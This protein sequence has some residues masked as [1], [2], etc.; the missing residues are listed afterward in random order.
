LDPHTNIL[1]STTA[2]Y[3]AV[4]GGCDSLTV[5]PF[6][7]VLREPDD[8][9]RRIAVNTQHILREECLG[10]AVADPAG[11]SWFVE[12]LTKEIAVNAWTEFQKTEAP[13]ASSTANQQRGEMS[14]RRRI[15]VG[16]NQYANPTEKPL[17]S[18]KDTSE[19]RLAGEFEALRSASWSYA[20]RTGSLPK[21]F[22]LTMG[23]LKQH[24][25]RADFSR[26]FLEPGGFEVIYPAGF[27][28]VAE[29]VTAA[30]SSR[31]LAAVLCST[32]ETYPELVPSVLGELRGSLPLILAGHPTEHIEAFKAAGVA[33]FIHLKADCGKFLAAW[34]QKLGVIS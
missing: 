13:D 7:Q 33:D 22:L 24:K 8:F 21:I 32:D 27:A 14:K 2:G 3:A 23:P 10:E 30:K 6:D 28:T 9:S 11:G 31:A 5:T 26:G 18:T 17:T 12:N 25:A 20:Q 34:Q 29:A 16:V 4:L 1:R 19:S 15:M